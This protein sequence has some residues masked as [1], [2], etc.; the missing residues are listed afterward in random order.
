MEEELRW[1]CGAQNRGSAGV[2]G[3]GSHHGRLVLKSFRSVSEPSVDPDAEEGGEERHMFKGTFYVD[4]ILR[5]L[6]RG[7]WSFVC[8]A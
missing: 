7:E 2:S 8:P 6:W 1:R 5:I 4:S 3:G